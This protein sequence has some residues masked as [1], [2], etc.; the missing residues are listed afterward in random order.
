MSSQALQQNPAAPAWVSARLQV[1][2]YKYVCIWTCHFVFNECF[3]FVGPI[4]PLEHIRTLK[5][6]F[7]FRSL[8][9]TMCNVR[10]TVLK[11][12]KSK[13]DFQRQQAAFPVPWKMQNR[14]LIPP[15]CGPDTLIESGLL[16][17][18][19]SL[20]HSTAGNEG[21]GGCEFPKG[22]QLT[23]QRSHALASLGPHSDSWCHRP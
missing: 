3:I 10:A 20:S 9:M 15:L 6:G 12:E 5:V 22:S 21:S 7:L 18:V 2:I 4:F 11:R 1:I 23:R 8:V 16:L 14:F 13:Q 17:A 19:L